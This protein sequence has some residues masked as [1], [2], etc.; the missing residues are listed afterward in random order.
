MRFLPSLSVLFVLVP[1]VA[2]AQE[3]VYSTQNSMR[4]GGVSALWVLANISY[5]GMRAQGNPSLGWRIASFLLGFPG[6]LVSLLAVEEGGERAY[7]IE[8]PRK[9]R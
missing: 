2:H 5:A 9:P 3:V 6:T 1:A 8:L 4:V 7:G